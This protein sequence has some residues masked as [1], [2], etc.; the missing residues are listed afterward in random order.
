MK[1]Q[2]RFT[3]VRAIGRDELG[4]VSEAI[5]N[6]TGRQVAVKTFDAWATQSNSSRQQMESALVALHKIGPARTPRPVALSISKENA[7]VATEWVSAVGLPFFLERMGALQP[8]IA[9]QI[10]C[11]ILDALV[12]IHSSGHA[13]GGLTPNKVILT[14]GFNAG[15]IVVSDPFQN[16]LY[17]VTD[18]LEALK[19]VRPL[20]FGNPKYLSPEQAR[21]QNPTVASDI[22]V[23]GLLLHEM[24]VGKPAFDHGTP[25][26]LVH[27]QATTSPTPLRQAKPDA[28]I[29]AD[30]EA[31]VQ[32]A[33]AK[34]PSARF[35]S[36][37][38]MRRALGSCRM[39]PFEESAEVNVAP[40]GRMRGEQIDELFI[41]E[42]AIDPAV[43]EAERVAAQQAEAMR[44]MEEARLQQEAAAQ[45][46]VR[47]E[48]M[49]AAAAATAAAEQAKRA[50]DEAAAREAAARD[51]AARQ[52]AQED[53]ARQAIA[54]EAARK[55][56][57]ND[58]A[59]RAARALAGD[60]GSLSPNER[61]NAWFRQST[62]ADV[63]ANRE[64]A[65][66]HPSRT[67]YN[68]QWDRRGR[69]MVAITTVLAMG[70]FVG[71][72]FLGLMITKG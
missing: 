31:I 4:E 28:G 20:F 27:A 11:G 37:L 5:D 62:D 10:A 13:H 66:T 47:Q 60:A 3:I 17:H 19:A 2:E 30:L 51:A 53:A 35:A 12:E 9:A 52:A 34:E 21:G 18:P 40:I 15:G 63:L 44:L 22:Y 33:L 57:V 59:G 24:I 26:E 48:A 14:G 8:E 71:M 68:A 16:E 42:P 45:E 38:A 25:Q 72:Y 67:G 1:L 50:A 49:A 64:F 36:A 43:L 70:A 32:L 46:R 61:A 7:W 6:T 56:E 23:V 41:A 65:S 54:N 58:A 29:S 39:I 55:A 69:R